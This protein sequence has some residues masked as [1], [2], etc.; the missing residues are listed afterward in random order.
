MCCL[1]RLYLFHNAAL[2]GKNVINTILYYH[3]SSNNQKSKSLY[4]LHHYTMSFM[5]KSLQLDLYHYTVCYAHHLFNTTNGFY[6]T[7]LWFFTHNPYILLS[8]LRIQM[9]S[10]SLHYVFYPHKRQAYITGMNLVTSLS[11]DVAD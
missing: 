5:H 3:N 2:R 8:S 4:I 11:D 6:I 10:L 7:T 1:L 9:R